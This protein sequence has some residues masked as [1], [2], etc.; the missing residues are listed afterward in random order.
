MF[1]EQVGRRTVG[2]RARY[3]MC[4]VACGQGREEGMD[5]LLAHVSCVLLNGPIC[6][7]A[8]ARRKHCHER[9]KMP[10]VEPQ[11]RVHSIPKNVASGSSCTEAISCLEAPGCCL[12]KGY[13]Q[14]LRGEA[15]PRFVLQESS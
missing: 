15:H 1:E 4:Q 9:R 5:D 13:G 11:V 3:G 7:E 6:V 12:E 2:Q 8:G 10:L 14:A